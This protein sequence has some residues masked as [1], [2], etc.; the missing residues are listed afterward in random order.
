MN[1]SIDSKQEGNEYEGFDPEV[2]G[3]TYKQAQYRYFIHCYFST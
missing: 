3:L 1:Y 2:F